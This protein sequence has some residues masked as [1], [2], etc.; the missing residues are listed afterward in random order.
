MNEYRVTKYNPAKRV[1]GLYLENEWSSY[2]DIGNS[3]NN[4]LLTSECYYK[5]EQ[6]YISFLM[7]IIRIERI[8]GVC[9]KQLEKYQKVRWKQGQH[10]K[11]QEITYLVRDCLREKCWCKLKND[12]FYIHF[13]YDYYMYIGCELNFGV[14]KSIA[15]K[16]NLFAEEMESPYK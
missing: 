3:F 4:K 2:Y 13:G 7:H 8:E 6:N 10:I 9:I 15:E 14:V 11:N 1:N 5:V 16:Y 12:N